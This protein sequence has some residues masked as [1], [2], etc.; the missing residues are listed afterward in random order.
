MN[1]KKKAFEENQ[2]ELS[3]NEEL[4]KEIIK[5][6]KNSRRNYS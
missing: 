1:P 2:K 6:I 4:L 3:E 5:K